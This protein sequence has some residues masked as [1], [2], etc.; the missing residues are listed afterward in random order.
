MRKNLFDFIVKSESKCIV[1]Y[2]A[3]GSRQGYPRQVMAGQ[4]EDYGVSGHGKA[5][6]GMARHGRRSDKTGRLIFYDSDS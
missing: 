2:V 6:Q 5:R 4:G 1:T 3:R